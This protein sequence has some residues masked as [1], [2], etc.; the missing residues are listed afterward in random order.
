MADNKCE[1][2]HSRCSAVQ[3]WDDL[4]PVGWQK[5]KKYKSIINTQVRNKRSCYYDNVYTVVIGLH[6]LFIYRLS[7]TSNFV[8]KKIYM[9]TQQ[10]ICC[11]NYLKFACGKNE[12]SELIALCLLEAKND[13]FTVSFRKIAEYVLRRKFEILLTH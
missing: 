5:R 7:K 6:S 10:N 2:R 11:T 12:S 8:S 4:V 1:E 13:H 9:N 3:D